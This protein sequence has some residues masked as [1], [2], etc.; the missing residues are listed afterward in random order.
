MIAKSSNKTSRSNE[1]VH[2]LTLKYAA[3][4]KAR[5]MQYARSFRSNRKLPKETLAQANNKEQRNL[6]SEAAK[7]TGQTR[8][9]P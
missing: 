1:T 5:Q 8:D 2:V 7:L 9:Q 6:W 4:H 3:T